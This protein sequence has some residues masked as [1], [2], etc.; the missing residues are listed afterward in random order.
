M[1]DEHAMW[2]RKRKRGS[3]GD[4]ERYRTT[5]KHR[6]RSVLERSYD[7]DG[8]DPADVEARIRNMNYGTNRR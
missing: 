1:V 5:A 6:L 4:D 8:D 2:W 3:R 7:F